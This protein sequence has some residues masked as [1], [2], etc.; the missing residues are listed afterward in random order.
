M[1]K[2]VRRRST[3]RNQRK[4]SKRLA[5]RRMSKRLTKRRL[6]KRRVRR[7]GKPGEGHLGQLPPDLIQQ[8]VESGK[9][10]NDPKLLVGLSRASR[11]INTALVQE[12]RKARADILAKKA[13]LED[14]KIPMKATS[15][16]LSEK[17][18][19]KSQEELDAVFQALQILPNLQHLSLMDNELTALPESLGN[20]KSLEWLSL[21]SNELTT[22]PN[23]LGKLPNLITLHLDGNRLTQPDQNPVVVALR[24]KGCEVNV[25]VDYG[26]DY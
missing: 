23:S 3:K 17:L 6:S 19:G 21:F 12:R 9:I 7:G 13:I 26:D 24:N 15:V 5:K 14:L 16:D 10:S 22:L 8:I 11:G 25:D 20:L 4:L 18:Q 2:R 1:T